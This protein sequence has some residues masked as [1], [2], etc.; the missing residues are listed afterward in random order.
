MKVYGI[1]QEG[2]DVKTAL[3]AT[4]DVL[5]EAGEKVV[6]ETELPLPDPDPGPLPPPL[7]GDVVLDPGIDGVILSTECFKSYR[8]LTQIINKHALF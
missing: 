6:R 1:K 8:I 4:V 2:K 3:P 7:L 5:G